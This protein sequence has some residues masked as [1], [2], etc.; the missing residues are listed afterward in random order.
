MPAGTRSSAS[1][2]IS[3]IK[4]R[5]PLQSEI[6]DTILREFILSG[7]LHPGDKMPSENELCEI[8]GASRVTIRTA[9]Q[10]LK[11]AGYIR[12]VRGSGSWVLPR[13]EAISSGLDRLVSFDTFASNSG[14]PIDTGDVEIVH[15]ARG[16]DESCEVFDGADGFTRVSRTKLID[17]RV[18]AWIVDYVPDDVLGTD[19]IRRSFKG[20]VLD[21]LLAH[22]SAAYSDCTLTPVIPDR[23]MA[24]RFGGAQTALLQLSELTRA[25]SGRIV[26][27]SEAWLT[28]DAFTFQLRRRRDN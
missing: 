19:E 15:L 4:S 13:P 10:G 28:P 17:G 3:R 25:D 14:H 27:R 21:V 8:F 5:R 26:N 11:D 7:R 16:D 23:A 2:D 24:D 18:I 20:S 22:H 12:I 6:R 1:K 9:M